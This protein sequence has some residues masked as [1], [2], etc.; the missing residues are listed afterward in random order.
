MSRLTKNQSGELAGSFFSFGED[1]PDLWGRT[2][3]LAGTLDR[4]GGLSVILPHIS[5]KGSN[6]S[7]H[8][9]ASVDQSR[10]LAYDFGPSMACAES[11]QMRPAGRLLC[12]TLCGA[13][14][15]RGTGQAGPGEGEG[16]G[17]GAAQPGSLLYSL[18][19]TEA[20]AWPPSLQDVGD[21]GPE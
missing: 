13:G 18:W 7:R 12:R 20:N 11:S 6:V 1:P 2:P 8:F 15:L 3:L 14:V 9:W 10:P 21:P 19:V 17:K 16:L 5:R 4:E